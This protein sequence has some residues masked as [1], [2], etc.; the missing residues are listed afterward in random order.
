MQASD[1]SMTTKIIGPDGLID[2]EPVNTAIS[3]DPPR[4]GGATFPLKNLKG[5]EYLTSGHKFKWD[6]DWSDSVDLRLAE[7]TALEYVKRKW[8]FGGTWYVTVEFSEA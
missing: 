3:V 7:I 6:T 5:V 4:W 8:W 1:K 2:I